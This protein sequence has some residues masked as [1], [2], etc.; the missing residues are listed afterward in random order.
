MATKANKEE[1]LGS[2]LAVPYKVFE[3]DFKRALRQK[4]MVRDADNAVKNYKEVE[5]ETAR[6]QKKDSTP[7]V[8]EDKRIKQQMADDKQDADNARGATSGFTTRDRV[9]EKLFAKGGSI[10]GGGCESRGKTK[11]RMV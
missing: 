5:A 10:R 6:G 9:G 4:A 11:G 1:Y 8:A 7:T 2:P 3:S